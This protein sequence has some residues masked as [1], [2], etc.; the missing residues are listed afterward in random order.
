MKKVSLATL[1]AIATIGTTFAVNAETKPETFGGDVHCR[2]EAAC[3]D[4]KRIQQARSVF[5]A[6][7]SIKQAK[8]IRKVCISIID[9]AIQAGRGL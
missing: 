8:G 1:I 7:V 3:M 4:L 5:L 2:K 9:L 6:I